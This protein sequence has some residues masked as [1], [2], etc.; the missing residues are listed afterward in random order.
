VAIIS[1]LDIGAPSPSDAQIQ[2]LVE[3]LAGEQGGP[4]DQVSASQITRL[5]IA[6]DSL[7][8]ALFTEA[9]LHSEDKKPVSNLDHGSIYS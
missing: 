8:P 4:E 6:G 3:Y 2:M 1:G 7:A 9:T 5:I